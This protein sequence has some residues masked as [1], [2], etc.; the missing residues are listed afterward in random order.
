MF[1]NSQ[2]VRLPSAGIFKPVMFGLSFCFFQFKWYTWELAS[3]SEAHWP[4]QTLNIVNFIM[5]KFPKQQRK[6]HEGWGRGGQRISHLLPAPHS[7]A[8]CL[9]VVKIMMQRTAKENDNFDTSGNYFLNY[10]LNLLLQ[11]AYETQ[12][13][14]NSCPRLQFSWLSIWTLSCRCPVKLST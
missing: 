2:L 8:H 13:G 11:C 9:S 12:Q 7:T 10:Q 14:R 4:L 3:C 1:V 6:Q 5:N